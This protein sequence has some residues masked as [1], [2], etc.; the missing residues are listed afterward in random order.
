[1]KDKP[2]INLQEKGCPDCRD[3]AEIKLFVSED[4]YRAF[5]RCVWILVNE[6]DRSQVEIMHDVVHDFLVKHGC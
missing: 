1:M 3:L 5:H 2:A 6:T 4:L